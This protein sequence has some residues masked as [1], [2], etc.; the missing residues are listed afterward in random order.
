MLV[1]DDH[2]SFRATAKALLAAE[3]FEV[4]GEAEDGESALAAL[5][6]LRPDVVLLDVQRGLRR[7][8]LRAEG[9]AL[10]RRDRGAPGVSAQGTAVRLGA[11]G[12]AIGLVALALALTSNRPSPAPATAALA[13]AFGWSFLAAGLVAHVRRPDNRTGRL[14]VWVSVSAFL[15]ALTAFDNRY[16]RANAR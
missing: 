10:G 4:V 16:A 15:A 5:R 3:G 14:M 11:V 8:G 6:R 2:P 12:A 13:I 9:R 7:A 1:V